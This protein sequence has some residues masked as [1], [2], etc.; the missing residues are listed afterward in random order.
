MS[1][2]IDGMSN[3]QRV[4][5]GTD[6]NQY[7]SGNSLPTNYHVEGGT[8]AVQHS[9]SFINDFQAG[10]D[11]ALSVY[12]SSGSAKNTRSDGVPYRDCWFTITEI[13]R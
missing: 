5:I 1:V 6:L 2:T 7:G 9:H 13:L 12:Q 10:D 4:I 8:F 11:L 3:G